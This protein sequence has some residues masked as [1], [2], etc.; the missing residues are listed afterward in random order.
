[1]TDSDTGPEAGPCEEFPSRE[2]RGQADVEHVDVD[3]ILEDIATLDVRTWRY[4]A[5][6]GGTVERVGPAAEEFYE[7]VGLWEDADRAVAG[8]ANGVALAAIQ[9]LARTVEQQDERI[10]RQAHRIEAQRETIAEQRDDLESLRATVESIVSGLVA[11]RGE[12]LDDRT[13]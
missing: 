12:A 13:P 7:T 8:D 4:T 1:M 10:E 11:L 6:D 5:E 3:A 9:A 2:Y